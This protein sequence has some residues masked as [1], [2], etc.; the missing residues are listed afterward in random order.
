MDYQTDLFLSDESNYETQ[1]MQTQA[2]SFQEK[3]LKLFTTDVF[4]IP[5]PSVQA[6]DNAME[7]LK[8]YDASV[9]TSLGK[10]NSRAVY[11]MPNNDCYIGI[12]R[13]G[14]EASNYHH[15]AG[16]MTCDSLNA[17][18][19]IRSWFDK[20]IKKSVEGSKFYAENPKTALALRKYIAAQF[21]PTAAMAIYKRYN[22]GNVYDPCGGWGDRMVAAQASGI[23]YHCRD[24]N[25]LVFA[26][27]SSQI[28]M[29]G[30]DISCELRG[31]EVDAPISNYFDLV[32]TS[33]PYWKIEKYQGKESSHAKFKKCDEWVDGFLKPMIRNSVE[34]LKDGGV[35]A[36]NISDCYANHQYNQLVNPTVEA[37]LERCDLKE[38]IGYRL[39]K[40]ANNKKLGIFCEPIIVGVKKK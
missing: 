4:P 40:R 22:A 25:P 23:S 7:M 6:A 1:W 37:I 24:V 13:T 21:R 30:G 9:L 28:A 12:N 36:I 8:T 32:F 34:S 14:M 31:S 19:P 15:W 38:I 3:K 5:S 35:I 16:R 26:G 18:S 10:W 27:Y 33:P 2:S 17:P 39:P 29:W 11:G 20:K